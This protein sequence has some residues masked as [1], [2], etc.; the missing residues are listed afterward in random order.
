MSNYQRYKHNASDN[1][2][3]LPEQFTDYMR[4]TD[5]RFCEISEI[6][7][8]DLTLCDLKYLHP[9]DLINIV[10]EN[11]YS[12][13]LLMSIMVRRYLF[14]DA[15]LCDDSSSQVC[16]TSSSQ[17]K[18]QDTVCTD[19]TSEHKRKHKHKHKHHKSKHHKD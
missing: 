7:L 16:D 19:T 1:S 14:R 11:Q 9:K 6:Y 2:S 8:K 10:P 5:T 17:S 3:T 13:K 4:G 15:D 18:S 12:H